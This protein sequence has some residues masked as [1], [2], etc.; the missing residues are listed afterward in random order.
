[1]G[2]QARCFSYG[3]KNNQEVL[4]ALYEDKWMKSIFPPEYAIANVENAKD[5][6]VNFYI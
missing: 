3:T 1:M 6:G 5:N 2:K 4:A